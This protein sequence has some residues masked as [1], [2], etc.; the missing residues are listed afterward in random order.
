MIGALLALLLLWLAAWAHLAF[1]SWK[2]RLPGAE[3]E[4]RYAETADGFRLAL[5]HRRPRAATR[6][7]PVLLLHGLAVNRLFMDF[8]GGRH[9]LSAHLAAA[10]FDCWALDLRGHGASPP[11]PAR[12]WSFDDYLRRDLPAALRV[13]REATGGGPV[14]LVG[15]S[16]GALLSLAGATLYPDQVAAVVALA[17][18]V[19]LPGGRRVRGFT[20]VAFAFRRVT[21]LAARMAAPLGGLLHSPI[22]QA[23]MNTRNVERPVLRRLLANA[24]EDVSRGVAR[25]FRGWIERGAF[26]STDGALDY[27]AGL[28]A[29]RQ[30]ALFVAGERDGLAPPPAVRAGLDAWGG[31]K[32]Y[33]LAA[34][35]TGFSADYGHGD[36]VFGRRAPE[37]IFPRISAWLLARTGG[38]RPR[39][40]P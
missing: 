32:E 19:R 6:G 40:A 11:G 28:A 38:R 39:S 14:A 25:Q 1:W 12:D 13:V 37:E 4:L 30:P 26:D 7:P 22:L 24:V 15:H 34:R 36:L 18:P 16:Q 8:G 33:L 2:L 31:E 21:R 9:S 35:A 23:S 29:A 5:G 17:G 3:D 10:G 20:R 27:R